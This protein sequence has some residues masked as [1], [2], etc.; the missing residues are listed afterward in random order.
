MAYFW[1][2]YTRLDKLA[3]DQAPKPA[4]FRFLT[5]L[6]EHAHITHPKQQPSCSA[7]CVTSLV[8]APPPEQRWPRQLQASQV[9]SPG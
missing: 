2:L 6:G 8:L 7:P 3:D 1:P 5:L 4:Y 9:G